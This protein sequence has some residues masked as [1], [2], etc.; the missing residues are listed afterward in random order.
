MKSIRES[1]LFHFSLILVFFFFNC[2]NIKTSKKESNS[3]NSLL[4]TLGVATFNESSSFAQYALANI[5]LS[6][7]AGAWNE[8]ERIPNGFQGDLENVVATYTANPDGSIQ[9]KNEGT[10]PTTGYSSIIGVAI[11]Y[12][13][14]KAILKVSFF[15]PFV[16]SDYYVVALDEVNYTYAM[17][18]SPTP[19]ILWIL[20]REKTLSDSIKTDLKS[21]ARTMGYNVDQ[22][23]SY[24]KQ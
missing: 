12:Q 13:S 23:R 10:S 24:I 14:P 18:G 4:L 11:P 16:F 3:S 17:V 8:I 6:K 21:K 7:Y 1:L 5:D 22:L 2:S 15:Y 19:N 9:V 20:A